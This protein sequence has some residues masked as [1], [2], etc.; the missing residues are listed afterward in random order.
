MRQTK[1]EVGQRVRIEGVV[2]AHYPSGFALVKPERSS[3]F[4]VAGDACVLT[5]SAGAASAEPV[6]TEKHVRAAHEM[7]GEGH[8][9]KHCD[10][11]AELLAKL[12]FAESRPVPSGSAGLTAQDILD[13]GVLSSHR[14]M[15]DELNRRIAARAGSAGL[16]ERLEKLR[17]MIG[18]NLQYDDAFALIDE[19]LGETAPAVP[20]WLNGLRSATKIWLAKQ[21][22]GPASEYFE[23]VLEVIDRLA[24]P[25]GPRDLLK[26]AQEITLGVNAMGKHAT[27][28]GIT[29]WVKQI[30]EREIAAAL[31]PAPAAPKE[32]K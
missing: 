20:P 22:G 9:P 27:A 15:A 2:R 23:D 13:V 25:A 29:M 5:G 10:I 8:R 30:L 7:L 17:G 16:R 24:A 18:P 21:E 3:D 19:M 6:V 1:L 28:T 14:Q 11:V 12:E 4:V 32:Q 26:V 31:A